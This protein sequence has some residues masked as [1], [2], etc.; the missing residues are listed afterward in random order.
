MNSRLEILSK[1][2]SNKPVTVS[3]P[4]ID[5]ELFNEEFENLSNFKK[6]V[7]VVGGTVFSANS[8]N[9]VLEQL[10]VLYPEARTNYSLLANSTLFNTIEL[11]EIQNPHDLEN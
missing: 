5:T 2:K 11:S 6:M 7:E 8:N 1:I 4:E 10:K 3:L 9:N